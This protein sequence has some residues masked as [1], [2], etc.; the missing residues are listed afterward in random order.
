MKVAVVGAGISGCL[1][2]NLLD[3]HGANVSVFEQFN[4]LGGRANTTQFE[5]GQCDLGATVVV[6]QNSEF[7]AHMQHLCRQGVASQWPKKILL[8]RQNPAVKQSLENYPS[9]RK[10]YVFNQQM[11]H[12]CRYWL[13]NIKNLHTHNPINQVRYVEGKGWQL[14]SK[15]VWQLE[16]FDNVILT[17]PWPHSQQLLEKSSLPSQCVDDAPSWS[18]CWSI[19]LK[20]QPVVASDIDL[21]Y[22]K[23][24]SIQT[25]VRDS[26]KP[27]RPQ[28]VNTKQG[29]NSEIWVAQLANKLSDEIGQAGKEYAIS[30]ATNALCELLDLPIDAVTHSEG[31]YWQYARPSHGQEPLGILS[32][33]NGMYIGGD[34][35]FGASIEAAFNGARALSQT[36][37]A[38]E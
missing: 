17:M 24:H 22:L 14:K 37:I 21:V 10:Y 30:L 13:R 4:D 35:S 16:W 15:Q 9:D 1:V 19:A 26:S 25:L 23:N 11:H 20:L 28:L 31:K 7:G 34:W 12:A 3:T 27:F 18:S 5:W 32:L 8:S 2:A 29:V 38:N 33:Q 6:A 36:L